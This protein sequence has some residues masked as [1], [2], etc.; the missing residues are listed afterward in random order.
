MTTNYLDDNATF[1]SHLVEQSVASMVLPSVT[2]ADFLPPQLDKIPPDLKEKPQ[3]VVWRAE[4]QVNTKPIKV[5]YDPTLPN[6]RAKSNDSHTWGTYAQAEAAYLEGGYTG[7]GFVL[8]GNGVVG[9]DIDHCVANG[10]PST[11]SM[12]LM[13]NLGVEYIETSPSGTGIRGFGYAENLEKGVNGKVDGLK[14]ELYSDLRFLTVTGHVLRSGPLSA[15]QGFTELANK[16]RGNAGTKSVMGAAVGVQEDRH[17][18]WMG[19]V[20]SGDVYHDSLRDLAGSMIAS[21]MQAGAV[22]SSLRGLMHASLGPRDDRWKTRKDEIPKLV[23][24]A[25]KKFSPSVVDLTRILMSTKT[26]ADVQMSATR[27]KVL[28]AS[29]IAQ[30]APIAWTIRG[31]LPK[32]GLAA[33]YGASGSGK[34][35][36]AL[37][38]SASIAAGNKDWYGLRVSNCP[39]T[40]CVLE[41]EAG[42]GKRVAAW[43]AHTQIEI[44]DKLRFIAQPFDIT[45]ASDVQELAEAIR[46]AGGADGLIVLDTLNRAAPGADEN[47][48]KDMGEIIANAKALQQLTGGMVLLVHHTGK[49]ESKGMRGHSSLFAAMDAVVAVMNSRE[50]GLSWCVAKSK[51]DVTGTT[52]PFRLEQVVV[53][54]DEEGEDITSCIAV[55]VAPPFALRKTKRLGSHQETA[56]KALNA[57]LGKVG[58]DAAGISIEEAVE[59]VAGEINVGPKHKRLRAKEAIEALSLK[60]Y[61]E[62][63][64][65][66]VRPGPALQ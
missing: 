35:F 66:R 62:I 41:G 26:A 61:I 50:K 15:L 9:I 54:T 17:A 25:V 12:K 7:M 23:D 53:G 60:Q 28:S 40:Y 20:I 4:G 14:V 16:I 39:V 44:A 65:H 33:L 3:W 38:M 11:G 31:L 18:L 49:D 22:V 5:P 51:D 52:Y 24:S 43:E 6:S 58:K 8:N 37:D 47:S 21:G 27:F 10:T 30:S 34:S 64:E 55:S 13:Q 63:D 1:S 2:I 46:A 29:E 19:Q 48:S 56:M 42:M 36:L 32:T 57:L 45:V 59:A